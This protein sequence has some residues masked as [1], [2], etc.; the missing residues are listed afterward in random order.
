MEVT[1]LRGEG[2]RNLRELDFSPGV[3]VNII[4]GENVQG[5]TNLLEALWLFCGAKSF[6][7]GKES[8]LVEFERERLRLDLDFVSEG[9]EQSAAIEVSEDGKVAFLNEVRLERMAE[10]SSIF[11]VVMFSPDHLELIKQGPVQ[12]RKF[13]D[14]ALTQVYPKYGEVLSG[15]DRILR[16]RG[17]LLSDLRSCSQP[18]TSL[19]VWDEALVDYGGYLAWMRL[20]YISKLVRY[21]VEIYAELSG[22]KERF[23][24]SYICGSGK[25]SVDWGRKEIT[26]HFAKVLADSR[27][28]DIR[29]K[30]TNKGPHRDDIDI[31]LDGQ[32]VRQYGSQG[33]QRSCVLA[34]KFAEC[35]I[36]E[37]MSGEPPIVLL[38]DVMSELDE[39]RRKFLLGHLSRNQVFITCCEPEAVSAA[40]E[41]KTFEMKAG[42]LGKMVATA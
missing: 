15:Y 33:Q 6:R 10:L 28:D 26:K 29:L 41:A 39:S 19:D 17:V 23:S 38:D 9:R 14:Q 8:E 21:A 4:H 11:R 20:R 2:F 30:R 22:G 5:K 37:E 34:L 24:A 13:I 31:M 7:F 36:L 40:T 12:R 42:L 32:S 35:R 27:K 18:N 3:G 25:L 1:R 16:Q